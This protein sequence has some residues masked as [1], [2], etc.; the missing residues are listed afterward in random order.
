MIFLLGGQGFIGSAFSRLFKKLDIECHVINRE[1][2][3]SYINKPCKVLINANGNSSKVIA[4]KDPLRDFQ[5]NVLSTYKLLLDIPS[6]FYI[7]LSSCDVYPDCSKTDTTREDFSPEPGEQSNYGFDKYL[8]EL[9]CRHLAKK[10]LIF[11]L[12]GFVG[13]GLKKNP[14]FDILHGD[15]LWVSPDSSFQFMDVDECADIIWKVYQAGYYNEVYNICA[16][17]AILISTIL[18]LADAR[19]RMELPST[20]PVHYNVNIEKIKKIIKIPDTYTA[21]KEYV[22]KNI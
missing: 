1:N 16:D 3:T 13:T 21:V 2:Y 7:H 6:D 18:G 15:K 8:G 9:C 4:K 10:W 5:A 20:P 14:V 19:N 12:G 17:G 11:R 22:E